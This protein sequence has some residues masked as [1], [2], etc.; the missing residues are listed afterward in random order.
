VGKVIDL[1]ILRGRV[2]VM[3][4]DAPPKVF[5]AS[6]LRPAAAGTAAG[7]GAGQDPGQGPGPSA[8]GQIDRDPEVEPTPATNKKPPL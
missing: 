7:P 4:Q 1:D 6:E 2:R 8:A 5:E 3:Y